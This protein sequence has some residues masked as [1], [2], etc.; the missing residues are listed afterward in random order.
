MSQ[1][2]QDLRLTCLKN[3]IQKKPMC[4]P[5]IIFTSYPSPPTEYLDLLPLYSCFST[6]IIYRGLCFH[7][8]CPHS[9][10]HSS[11][12]FQ[13]N[14]C[15]SLQRNVCFDPWR[16][17][18]VNIVR[19][20]Y[21][22][23]AKCNFQN[24]NTTLQKRGSL[25]KKLRNTEWQFQNSGNNYHWRNQFILCV[26]KTGN[27]LLSYSPSTELLQLHLSQIIQHTPEN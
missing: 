25:N 7:F 23:N 2:C 16:L 20:L 18:A 11:K 22:W 8:G 21:C 12:W 5:S 24:F 1:A 14:V 4:K 26:F 13:G 6:K 19:N 15:S 27:F 3:E 17:L 9:H 10:Q